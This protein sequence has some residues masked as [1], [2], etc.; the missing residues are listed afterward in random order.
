ME[1]DDAKDYIRHIVIPYMNTKPNNSCIRGEMREKVIKI[2]R[3]FR[4]DLVEYIE[5]KNKIRPKA[6]EKYHLIYCFLH[7]EPINDYTG[8]MKIDQDRNRV[9][10]KSTLSQW[11]SEV[12]LKSQ[13]QTKS[14]FEHGMD[15]Q[16]PR[17]LGYS[18]D[19]IRNII[20][21]MNSKY[22]K[23]QICGKYSKITFKRQRTCGRKCQAIL[24]S[25]RMSSDWNPSKRCYDNIY[26][27]ENRK[28]RSNRMKELIA[29]GEFTPCITNSWANSRVRIKEFDNCF[30]STWE[31]YFY[32][33][34]SKNDHIIEY[35]KLRIP[36]FDSQRNEYRNYITD[37][38]DENNRII[39]EIKPECNKIC[40]NVIDKETAAI[41]WCKEN[42]YSY[43]FI[44]DDWFKG[45]YDK[46]LVYTS[47][48]SDYNRD[49]LLNAL[50]QFEV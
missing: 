43:Q 8:Y 4:P 34:M 20:K 28:K 11:A 50:K 36:Y 40:Q 2:Y 27:D 29:N 38:L 41:K 26:T 19:Y 25:H 23:C 49:K 42:G 30:R 12:S 44:S 37:F 5:S 47:D 21:K 32:L 1:I 13:H 6:T 17:L 7:D 31:A 18:N 16:Y 15:I 35:E 46:E 3:E 10:K 48:I 9:Y 14:I 33:H 39:Y 45:N 22:L 24:A